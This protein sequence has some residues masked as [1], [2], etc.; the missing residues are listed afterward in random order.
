MFTPLLRGDK[1]L[2]LIR[3]ENYADLIIILDRR[4]SESG[5]NFG[6]TFLLSDSASAEITASAHVN[7]E[8]D[9]EFT[10]LL[11]DLN[12]RFVV[13]RS[14]VPIDIADIVAGHILSDFGENYTAPLE[15]AVI[16][17]GKD[18]LAQATSFDLDLTDLLEKFI[19]IHNKGERLW[20]L[21][22][23]E[24]RID[25][26]VGAY[27]VGF[28]LVRETDTVAEHVMTDSADIL[29]DDITATLEEGVSAG[30]ESEAD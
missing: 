7:E 3:E 25:D 30:S 29:G 26:I 12:V 28:R 8:H 16:L 9:G 23:I 4:E 19:S 18:V 15:C 20:H 17:T 13:A 14:N 1:L 2:D 22:L 21:Y 11:I 27:I 5:S 6:H 10:F 24:D